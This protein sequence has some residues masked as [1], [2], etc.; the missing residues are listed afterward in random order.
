M[1]ME[2]SNP[3]QPSPTP[4]N[5]LPRHPALS[6]RLPPLPPIARLSTFA[7]LASDS[8][9]PPI[10]P[11]KIKQFTPISGTVHFRYFLPS[12]RVPAY[13]SPE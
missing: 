12:Y 5:L 10:I 7:V 4:A 9:P 13:R 8:P 1:P 6:R 11:E 3:L 2:I